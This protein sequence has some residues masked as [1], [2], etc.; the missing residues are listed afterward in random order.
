VL[1]DQVDPKCA[2]GVVEPTLPVDRAT[3]KGLVRCGEDRCGVGRSVIGVQDLRYRWQ[4]VGCAPRLATSIAAQAGSASRCSE[5]GLASGGRECGSAPR[6][7]KLAFVGG[8]SVMSPH[9]PRIDSLLR[10]LGSEVGFPR[11]R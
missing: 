1:L 5:V 10:S 3:V 2:D 11:A 7:V 8:I 6:K 9:H 4:P